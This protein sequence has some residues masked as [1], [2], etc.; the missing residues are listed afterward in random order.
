DALAGIAVLVERPSGHGPIIRLDTL[1][2][3][4]VA[5]GSSQQAI[6]EDLVLAPLGRAG[7]RLT[8]VD[9]YATEMHN[10]EITEP[11]GGG[12]IPMG[13]YRLIAALGVMRGHIPRDGIASFIARHGMSGYAP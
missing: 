9:R 2:V 12:N 3:H 1:G 11:A 5:S 4:P 13:N 8:D 10:P 7:Y 6:V